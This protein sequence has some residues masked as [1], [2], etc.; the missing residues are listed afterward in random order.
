KAGRPS[1]GTV[2]ARHGGSGWT[3]GEPPRQRAHRLRSEADAIVVGIGT[4]LR[5]DPELTVRLLQPW[6]REPLR[7]VLDTAARIPVGARL[8]RAGRPSSAVIAVGAAAPP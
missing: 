1:D 5:D 4:V 3:P 6:P 7:V 2:P 8:I